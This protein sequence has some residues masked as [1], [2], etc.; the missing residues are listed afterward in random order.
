MGKI[1]IDKQHSG[2]VTGFTNSGN[3]VVTKKKWDKRVVVVTGD[4]EE[5][6]VGT[7]LQ[8]SISCEHS[9]HYQAAA[10]GEGKSVVSKPDYSGSPNIPIHHDGK[11]GES[12]GDTRSKKKTFKSPDERET[13][14]ETYYAPKLNKEKP[15]RTHL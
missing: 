15:D 12:V 10:A 2:S 8:F 6:S 11:H 14:P 13:D 5:I 3:P 9:D 7:R 1:N 4:T